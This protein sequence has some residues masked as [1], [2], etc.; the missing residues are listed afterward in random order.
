M[1]QV[2]STFI[3]IF[4]WKKDKII[5]LYDHDQLDNWEIHHIGVNKVSSI[6]TITVC[7]FNT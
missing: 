3:R 7:I 2:F 4:N 1:Q 5:I 6:V